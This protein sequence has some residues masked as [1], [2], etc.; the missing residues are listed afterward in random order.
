MADPKAEV[1]TIVGDGSYLY[2]VPSSTYW[3]AQAYR[4]PQLTIVLN[5]GGWHAPKRS[6]LLVHPDGTANRRDRY[7]VTV[8]ARTRFAD[9]AAAAGDAVAYRVS[10]STKLRD[11][12]NEALQVVRGGR[13]AVVDIVMPPISD[14]VLG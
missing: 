14:Q 6:T 3:V 8:G 7:W 1:I 10:S 11:T 9:I 13:A 4:V 2:G 12:L 5:N